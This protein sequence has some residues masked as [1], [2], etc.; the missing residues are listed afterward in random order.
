MLYRPLG[1]DCGTSYTEFMLDNIVSEK[2]TGVIVCAFIL[3]FSIVNSCIKHMRN[4][5][6]FD[7][8]SFNFRL[9]EPVTNQE[10]TIVL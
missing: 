2:R 4:W 7:F 5:L 8:F 1:R 9:I 3:A 10:A 6:L